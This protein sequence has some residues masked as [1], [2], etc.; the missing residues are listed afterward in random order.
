MREVK[1]VEGG[2]ARG[3]WAFGIM[4]E[5]RWRRPGFPGGIEIAE[6]PETD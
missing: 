1:A 5:E 4:T 3:P 6:S 2:D